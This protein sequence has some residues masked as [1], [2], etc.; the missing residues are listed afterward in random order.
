MKR[1]YII[2]A[3]YAYELESDELMQTLSAEET[4]TTSKFK[5]IE[6]D[7]KERTVSF[8]DDFEEW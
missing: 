2:P 5:I 8:A 7:S 6:T 3:I 4:R 1:Q